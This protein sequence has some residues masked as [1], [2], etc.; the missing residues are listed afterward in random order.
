VKYGRKTS[1]VFGRRKNLYARILVVVSLTSS[2]HSIA[3][4]ASKSYLYIVNEIDLGSYINGLGITGEKA[5]TSSTG[6]SLFSGSAKN[7]T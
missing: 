7:R 6:T 3:S 2:L 5:T 4:S 1:A